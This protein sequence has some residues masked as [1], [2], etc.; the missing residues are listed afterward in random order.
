[1]RGTVRIVFEIIRKEFYQIRQ[2][3]RMLVVSI[4]APVLQVILLGYAATLDI[5]NT[6]LVV[7]DLDRT[8][9]SREFVRGFTSSGHFVQRYAVDA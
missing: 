3:R 7:C 6:K 2:D 8:S 4:V 1:M 5:T 9:V